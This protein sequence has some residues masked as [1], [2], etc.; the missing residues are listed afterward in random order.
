MNQKHE[1]SALG[2]FAPAVW[3]SP[4]AVMLYNLFGHY[5]IV[6]RPPPTGRVAQEGGNHDTERIFS[7]PKKKVIASSGADFNN[8]QIKCASDALLS[9]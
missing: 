5:R 8:L 6:P 2:G 4:L 9:R 1:K 7:S 3:A